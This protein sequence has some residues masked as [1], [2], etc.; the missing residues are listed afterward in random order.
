[1]PALKRHVAEQGPA[2][3]PKVDFSNSAELD[4][5]LQKCEGMCLPI[6]PSTLPNTLSYYPLPGL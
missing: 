3:S 5:D 2:S 6:D 4:R 1:M